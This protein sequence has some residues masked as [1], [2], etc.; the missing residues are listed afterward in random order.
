MPTTPGP[1]VVYLNHASWWDPLIGLLLARRFWPARQHYAP[2]DA[3]QLKRYRILSR[4]GFFGVEPG[5]TRGAAIF[6]RNATAILESADATL[7]ITSEG[8]FRDPRSRPVQLRPGVAHLAH[9]IE[10]V[11]FV[12]LAIEYPFWEERFPEVLCRFGK[13]IDSSAIAGEK[14]N[15]TDDWMTLLAGAMQVNQDALASESMARRAEA[16]QTILGGRAGVG[17]IY[18]TW[19]WAMAKMKG[20]RFQKQHG[21]PSP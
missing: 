7:W 13:A 15:T 4:I 3:A 16:F 12:P 10:Q 8:Q 20:E 18:D 17:G 14:P 19:R 2:I 5:T 9:R 11:S 21:D 1:M 6:L